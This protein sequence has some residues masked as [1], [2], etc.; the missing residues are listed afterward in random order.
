MVPPYCF[1]LLQRIVRRHSVGLMLGHRLRRWPN[2]K[3]TF[4]YE[5]VS[6]LYKRVVIDKI[7]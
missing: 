2:I 1:L 5:H 6:C 7:K 4:L 3:P